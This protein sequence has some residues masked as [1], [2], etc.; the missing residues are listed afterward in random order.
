M[1]LEIKGCPGKKAQEEIYDRFMLTLGGR[2]S[3]TNLRINL[4]KTFFYEVRSLQI[5][6]DLIA[7]ILK[8][9]NIRS[10][11]LFLDSEFFNDNVVD[12]QPF[13]YL[14]EVNIISK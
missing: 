5:L 11:S 4:D 14:S 7:K 12:L 6:D 8:Q 1:L 13:S 3:F 9:T 10:S 2:G